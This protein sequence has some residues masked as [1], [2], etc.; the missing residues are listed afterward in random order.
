MDPVLKERLSQASLVSN[1]VRTKIANGSPNLA[2]IAGLSQTKQDELNSALKIMRNEM[3][4]AGELIKQQIMSGK[5]P[6]EVRMGYFKR[7][8]EIT[9]EHDVANCGGFATSTFW[10]LYQKEVFPITFIQVSNVKQFRNHSFVAIGLKEMAVGTIDYMGNWDSNTV[11]C[12]PWLMQLRKHLK[13]SKA[14]YTGAYTVEEFMET[15]KPYF[16]DKDKVM[17]TGHLKNNSREKD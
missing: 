11:I 6:A 16:N 14:E 1:T 5:D 4:L 12:D 13:K 9:D 2:K 7:I 3:R 10:H 17:I 8:A 15:T